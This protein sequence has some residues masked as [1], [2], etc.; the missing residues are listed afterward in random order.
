MARPALVFAG[1]PVQPTPRLLARVKA[2]DEPFV[3]A[4]DSGAATA[5]AFGVLPDVLVGDFDSLAPETISELQARGVLVERFPRAK[6]ATDG[7]LAL[8]RALH[9]SP[10]EVLLVGF[11]G[12]TRFDQTVA[13]LLLAGQHQAI[14]LDEHN[15]GVVLHGPA[16]RTW[17]S[18]HDEVTSLVPLTHVHG[19]STINMRYPLDK[20]DLPLGTTRGVS[21]EPAADEVGI[22]LTSG[23]LLLVRHFPRG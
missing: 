11:L 10:S 4:A 21:N 16:R 8:L 9:E 3:V 13:N 20:E 5:L 1:V 23:S 18:E 15:D 6:D 2:L 12:G 14:L 7:E 22:E 19:V 17:H